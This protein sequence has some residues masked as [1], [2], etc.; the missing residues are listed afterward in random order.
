MDAQAAAYYYICFRIPVN[1]CGI[2]G[3][4]TEIRGNDSADPWKANQTAM[5]V[6]GQNK[7]CPPGFILLHICR[8][9]RQQDLIGGI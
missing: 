3:K 1:T 4:Q 6:A 9:M 7:I 5:D 2:C 8:I